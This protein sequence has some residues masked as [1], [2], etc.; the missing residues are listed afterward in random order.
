MKLRQTLRGCNALGSLAILRWVGLVLTL[1]GL[2]VAVVPVSSATPPPNT[3]TPT[4]SGPTYTVQPGDT[5]SGIAQRFN[6]DLQALMRINGIDDPTRIY[7]GMPLVLPGL[8]GVQG[9]L[10]TVPVGW[11]E[12]LWSLARRYRI[13]PDLLARLNRLVTPEHLY[14]G[15]DL[16]LPQSQEEPP[17][18]GR[19]LL[20][21]EES[22]LEAAVR[23]GRNP[24]VLVLTNQ[25]AGPWEALAGE[26]LLYLDDRGTQ[27]LG[28]CPPQVQ[29]VGLNPPELRQGQAW[30]LWWEFAPETSVGT[31][32]GLW[33]GRPMVFH[34][35]LEGDGAL[36]G[37]AGPSGGSRWVGLQGV[38][39]ML[40]PQ[41]YPLSVT[42]TFGDGRMWAFHQ[43]LKVQ[44][45]DFYFEELT[46]PPEFLDQKTVQEEGERV[47][48]LMLPVTQPKRWEGPFQA[49]I[50]KGET[51]VTSYF[52]TR[53]KFN[54]G[55]AWGYHAGVDFCGGEGTPIYAPAPGRVVLARSLTIRGNAVILDHGWGVY[56]GYWHMAEFTVEEGQEVKTGDLL[57]YVGGTGR[58][59]GPHLHWELWVGGVPVDPLLWLEAPLP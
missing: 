9:E 45:G 20:G 13:R 27:D 57:G 36:S 31:L 6:V 41:V 10:T 33:R 11:C 7:P 25:K 12:D 40:R 55:A 2:F 15:R 38:H 29:A 4:P 34:P 49:P 23:I 58:V 28:A 1:F 8:P 43:P 54:M 32:E 50:E 53:R 21:S 44:P 51:C 52:G 56:T 48:S 16:I 37:D 42:M 3:P 17:R 47:R 24:W 59:T 5:L 19:Y 35:V 14:P 18:M 46:V 26:V 30:A 39:A 22:L